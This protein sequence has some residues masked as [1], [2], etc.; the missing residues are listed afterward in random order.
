MSRL[1]GFRALLWAYLLE[2]WRSK[3]ALFWNLLFPLLTLLVVSYAFASGEPTAVPR[4][5]PGILTINLLAAAFFGI[6]LFMVSL[7][8]LG[9]YRRLFMTPLTAVTVVLAHAAVS[10]F[11]IVIST[12]LQIAIARVLFHTS[13]PCS[14]VAL[15]MT[16][17]LGAFAFI[18][19]GLLVGSVAQSMRTAPVLSNLLFFPLAFLSGAA[20]PLHLMPAW[21]QRIAALLPSTYLVKLLQA[22]LL[23]GDLHKEAA[24]AAGIL[25]LT[26]VIGLVGNT[27]L[28]RWD[29]GQPLGSHR[30]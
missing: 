28:F 7:R 9:I 1:R 18:P 25:L 15:G 14:V 13:S 3:P 16:V 26:G 24:P 12:G 30:R 17:L 6:S 21:T 29:S 27:L 2:T 10:L 8:E 19:V 22:A 20:I 23:H 5:L 11:Y 4:T